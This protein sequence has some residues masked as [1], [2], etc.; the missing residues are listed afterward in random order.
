MGENTLLKYF[1]AGAEIDPE[2]RFHLSRK[3]RTRRLKEIYSI[4]RKHHFLRGFTPEVF[5]AVLEDLGPS[6]VKI[7]QTLSTRS[8]IL[9]KAYC[10]ELAKLQMEC[11]PLPFE[12]ILDAIDDIYGDR[13]S[14]VFSFIDSTPLGS[15]SLAQVHKARLVS[16]ETVAVKI[17]RPGVKATMAQD[18]DIM[19]TVARTASRFMKDEQMLDMREVVE[20]LWATFLE[21][22]D[23][24]REAENLQEFAQRNE[25]VAFIDC[26][27]VYPELCS[28]YVLV[29]EYVDGIPILAVDRLRAAGYEVARIDTVDFGRSV[30][31]NPLAYVRTQ[32]D[33]LEV[34]D[35]IIANT[36]REGAS[37][38]D[39]F[40]ENAERLL[41]SALVA[42]LV[43]HCPEADR[44][45]PGLMTLLSLASAS[46]GDEGYRSPLDVLFDELETGKR[47]VVGEEGPH[48]EGARSFTGGTRVAW[49]RVAEPLAPEDDFALGRYRAFRVAAGRTLKSII[50]SCNA[51]L[52][53]LGGE[54]IRRVLSGD[55]LGIDLM[56]EP[57]RRVAIFAT[58]SDTNGT[59]SFLLALLVWQATNLLCERALRVHGGSLPTPVHL[60]LDEFANIGRLPDFERTIA[61]VRSRNIGVSVILQSLSQLKARY[62]ESAQTIVDCCDTTLFLGGNSNETNRGI[63]EKVGK[64]TVSVIGASESRGSSSSSTQSRQAAERDL[65]QPSELARLDR[66]NAIVLIAGADP[67]MDRKY[68]PRRHPA[69]RGGWSR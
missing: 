35:C 25:Q 51:R 29:M 14:E 37:S 54:E 20:E 18:I 34:V 55:D 44:N 15:A 2:D 16:G 67:V 5:R 26:P 33:V 17:Q 27:K 63:S 41:Y 48:Q 32:Q 64:Q 7:G 61:V 12:Q 38:A 62:G 39:P 28:E 10:D 52:A 30:R 3:T 9:P 22:T 6:F 23:F 31:Y 36:T 1:F 57:G 46:E 66:R 59:F 68:D 42:Y 50:I 43:W 45:L 47:C 65:I 11:D 49:V 19:R 21:E 56:G 13:R 40:W 4:L 60:V 53:P 58:T 8:E 69:W 24:A